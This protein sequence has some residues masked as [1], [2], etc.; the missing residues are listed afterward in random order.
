MSRLFWS[1]LRTS[2]LVASV[3]PSALLASACGGG[4][5]QAAA[6]AA[7]AVIEIG[8][9]NVITVAPSSISVGPLISGELRAQ[10]EAT[11]RAEIGG[12]VVQ[13][14][15]DEGQAVKQGALLARI[16]A[17]TQQDA[18]LSA[19]SAVR[20]SEE[21]LQNA[22]RELERT[23]R[24]VKGGALA[25][26]DLESARNAA[27]SAR[28]QRDDARSRLSSAQKAM[29]D[30]T[31]RSPIAGIVSQ[32]HVNAGDVVSPGGE[33]YTV[34]DP[35]SMR[36][37]AS[38]SSDQISSITVGA[39]V[40][41]E[42]RGYPGQTF[43]GRIERISPSADPVTRQIP[44]FVAIPNTGGRLVAGLFAQGRV[45]REVRSGL[46]VPATAVTERGGK[47]TVLRVRE[48]KAERVDVTIGLRD[49]Q[50]ERV[51][52]AS[53]IAQGDVLLVGAAQGMTPGTPVRVRNGS[54]SEE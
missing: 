28:A 48:G 5:S 32:R 3:V 54:P 43:E 31:V 33:L 20:S 25:E 50:T 47:A 4:A 14:V 52:I 8:G 1:V 13:V 36:L 21:A 10:R 29:E 53:G 35:S 19:Q 22:E 24:L 16:E 15:P 45:L 7:P 27:I 44:I 2:T 9:E 23:E 11:V 46:V 18:Y 40:T 37:E 41:F 39:P 34:I 51:E 30:A 26:R 49:E 38:V 42:V 12:S 17:R 6:P